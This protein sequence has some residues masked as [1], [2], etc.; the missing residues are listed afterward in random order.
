[1][2][3]QLAIQY[4]AHLYHQ[5]AEQLKSKE[6]DI[7]NLLKQVKATEF[8]FRIASKEHVTYMLDSSKGDPWRKK[9][10]DSS[11]GKP[12]LKEAKAQLVKGKAQLEEAQPQLEKSWKLGLKSRKSSSL[13][14]LGV[15]ISQPLQNKI[16]PTKNTEI[17]CKT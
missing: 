11:L 3:L 9:S 10:L 15:R 2:W 8:T 12:R 13:L 5:I 4:D 16:K 1:M 6:E 7:D 14:Y 17:E